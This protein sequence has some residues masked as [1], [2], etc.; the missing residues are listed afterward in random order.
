MKNDDSAGS[1]YDE[2]PLAAVRAISI[3]LDLPF[4]S[5]IKPEVGRDLG[6]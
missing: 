6:R 5:L 2:P 3:H 1:T 4:S